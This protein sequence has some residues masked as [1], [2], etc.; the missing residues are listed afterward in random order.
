MSTPAHT[1]CVDF[2]PLA[3]APLSRRRTRPFLRAG[4]LARGRQA[5]A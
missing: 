1:T 5:P 4:V 2:L 3:P